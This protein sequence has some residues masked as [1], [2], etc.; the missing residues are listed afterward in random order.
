MNF[1]E[2]IL[3]KHGELATITEAP[4]TEAPNTD[5]TKVDPTVLG[6]ETTASP[7]IKIEEPSPSKPP[8][9]SF[10]DFES[11]IEL[12]A[13]KLP[14]F[15]GEPIPD[16]FRQVWL[17][18]CPLGAI[19]TAMTRVPKFQRYIKLKMILESKA[20]ILSIRKKEDFE[21]SPDEMPTENKIEKLGPPENSR[22]FH[23][24]FYVSDSSS[25]RGI[26]PIT[27][28][29]SGALLFDIK[30]DEIFYA[31][32]LGGSLWPSIAEKAYIQMMAFNSYESL[33]HS[34]DVGMVML[35]MTG[36]EHMHILSDLTNR[37]LKTLIKTNKVRPTVIVSKLRPPSEN[38]LENHT[39]AVIGFK[40]DMV[41]LVDALSTEEAKRFIWL[42]I[43]DIRS[44]FRALAQGAKEPFG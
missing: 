42:S 11:N 34:L 4:A 15:N 41:H 14:L 10:S 38:V 27:K 22:L 30:R 31:V 23:V 8:I 9:G 37:E 26:R 25:S 3:I 7:V 33:N 40:E 6:G 1:L 2:N 13:A 36:E 35:H 17:D 20:N 29:V 43:A 28:K 12:R 21:F 32:G 44:N 5:A 24:K 19:M 16:E 18:N 39:Y